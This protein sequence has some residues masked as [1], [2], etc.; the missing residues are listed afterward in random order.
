MYDC[1]IG[2]AG[3]MRCCKVVLTQNP[4]AIL[5]AKANALLMLVTKAHTRKEGTQVMILPLAMRGMLIWIAGKGRCTD[6]FHLQSIVIVG[7]HRCSHWQW[8]VQ[9]C[10]RCCMLACVKRLPPQTGRLQCMMQPGVLSQQSHPLASGCLASRVHIVRCRGKA[11]RPALRMCRNVVGH[12]MRRAAASAET[13]HVRRQPAHDGRPDE[14]VQMHSQPHTQR[15]QQPYKG[16]SLLAAAATAAVLLFA[17]P[18]PASA[19]EASAMASDE[20]S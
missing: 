19:T 14:V 11:P 10:E 17:A 6:E 1:C 2:A 4:A 20:R 3:M 15:R 9:G 16:L 12:S 7:L 18:L 5:L 8:V 13:A